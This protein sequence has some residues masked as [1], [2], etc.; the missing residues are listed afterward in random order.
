[1]TKPELLFIINEEYYA[2]FVAVKGAFMPTL[3][4]IQ[5]KSKK[6]IEFEGERLLAELL[7]IADAHID[8]PCGGRGV[9]R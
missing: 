6:T 9:C 3:T 2:F 7:D 4:V 1:M 8:K 5:N